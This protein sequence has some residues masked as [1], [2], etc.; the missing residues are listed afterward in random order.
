M[1]RSIVSGATHPSV[2]ALFSL[3]LSALLLQLYSS[4]VH[5]GD[6]QSCVLKSIQSLLDI[7]LLACYILFI[8]DEKGVEHDAI[9]KEYCYTV[10]GVPY[11]SLTLNRINLLGCLSKA[12]NDIAF[13]DDLPHAVQIARRL[14]PPINAFPAELS[15]WMTD[16][17]VSIHVAMIL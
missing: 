8:E 3:I 7:S 6:S 5:T 2:M 11:T 10:C 17:L 4:V 15:L 14:S 9:K 13:P 1:V 12:I 16:L